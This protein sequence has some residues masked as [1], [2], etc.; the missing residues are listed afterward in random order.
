MQRKKMHKQ[1]RKVGNRDHM[2]DGTACFLVG[3]AEDANFCKS[4]KKNA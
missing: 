1:A 4:Q 3:Q 2:S